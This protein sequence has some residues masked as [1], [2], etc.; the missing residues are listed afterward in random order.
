MTSK[1]TL[2]LDHFSFLLTIQL[3]L[4]DDK[5]EEDRLSSA[6]DITCRAWKVGHPLTSLFVSS[7]TLFLF[8]QDRFDVPYT[9]CGCPL[10]GETIGQKLSRLVGFS[11]TQHPSH[12]IP[13]ERDD[14][15]AATHPSDHN[16]VFAFHHKTKGEVAQ[17]RRRE[18][19]ARRR[20][21]AD[22]KVKSGKM[23]P[24]EAR[25]VRGHEAAFLVPVPLYFMP[26]MAGC[27]MVTGAVINSSGG[28]GI[29][30]CA[31]VCIYC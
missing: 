13:P 6:F 26:V 3:S 30:G 16:A 12:L 27:A 24:R 22:E 1:L 11:E 18:K 14:L 10:P 20:Q 31:A 4:S 5:V 25:Q 29:G 7:F 17:R 2:F 28:G 19:I 21:R 15:L 9:H 23:D 8:R